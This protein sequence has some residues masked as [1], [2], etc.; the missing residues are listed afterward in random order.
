VPS[1]K[2]SELQTMPQRGERATKKFLPNQFEAPF[3][4]LLSGQRIRAQ[5]L[6]AHQNGPRQG[7]RQCVPAASGSSRVVV[8]AGAPSTG[9]LEACVDDCPKQRAVSARSSAARIKICEDKPEQFQ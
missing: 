2:A 5:A 7:L 9:L 6:D 4:D 8:G 3:K 1:E